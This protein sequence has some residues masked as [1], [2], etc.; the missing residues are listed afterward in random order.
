[1]CFVTITMSF[2]L[3]KPG[4]KFQLCLELWHQTYSVRYKIKAVLTHLHMVFEWIC[5]LLFIYAVAYC[6][7]STLQ[8]SPEDCYFVASLWDSVENGANVFAI[9]SQLPSVQGTCCL[10]PADQVSFC[11]PCLSA[12]SAD[13]SS[14]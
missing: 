3:G 1:M 9:H 10:K 8:W 13:G 7:L 4:I 12:L 2:Y 14:L 6:N 11:V 5:K